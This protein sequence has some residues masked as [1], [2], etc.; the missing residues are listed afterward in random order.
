MLYLV[1]LCCLLCFL[2]PDTVW[3]LLVLLEILL[4]CANSTASAKM[5]LAITPADMTSPRSGMLRFCNK[6]GSSGL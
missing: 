2:L 5:M 4:T 6:S 1:I 3:L